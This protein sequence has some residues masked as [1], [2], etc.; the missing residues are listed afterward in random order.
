LP[1]LLA[2]SLSCVALA[3]KCEGACPD[4]ALDMDAVGLLQLQKD[5]EEDPKNPSHTVCEFRALDPSAPKSA[6]RGTISG[7]VTSRF[8]GWSTMN[9]LV[10]QE[11][12]GCG[13][14]LALLGKVKGSIRIGCPV[15]VQARS[16]QFPF[17]TFAENVTSL[18]EMP[19]EDVTVVQP[20]LVNTGEIGSA[21]EGRLV[22]VKGKVTQG[23]EGDRFYDL[24]YGYNVYADD[25][26]GE[27]RIS[28]E[29]VNGQP[30]F[31]ASEV[32]KGCDIQVV[33]ASMKY[34]DDIKIVPQ[35]PADVTITC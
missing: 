22:M 11:E 29:I 3:T 33:G 17:G 35:R 14:Y 31:D 16:R 2:F 10:I 13:V 27:V 7:I 19:C 8:I 18:E 4:E 21:N 28:A 25:G 26:S 12:N 23:V 34:F 1:L 32:K 30:A 6:R 24:P 9:G 15:R 5:A 20:L